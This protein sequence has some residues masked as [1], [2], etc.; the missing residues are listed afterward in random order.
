MC[1]C[2]RSQSIVYKAALTC[3]IIPLIVGL[4]PVCPICTLLRSPVF[5]PWA[6]VLPLR[7]TPRPRRRLSHRQNT[8]LFTIGTNGNACGSRVGRRRAEGGL[9]ALCCCYCYCRYNVAT[10]AIVATPAVDSVRRSGPAAVSPPPLGLRNRP[11][12]FSA[13]VSHDLAGRHAHR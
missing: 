8:S 11:N 3:L 5:C 6:L 10:S 4:F 12:I 13:I 2:C 9:H 7:L 1:K